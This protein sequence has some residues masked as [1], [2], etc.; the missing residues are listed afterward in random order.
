[1]ERKN[2]SRPADTLHTYSIRGA[3]SE[4]CVQPMVGESRAGLLLSLKHAVFEQCDEQAMSMYKAKVA[5]SKKQML[6]RHP[7]SHYDSQS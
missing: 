5:S 6:I 4:D 3:D 1:M 2:S 7:R